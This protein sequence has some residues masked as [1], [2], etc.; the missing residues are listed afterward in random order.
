MSSLSLY[1][2]PEI[3][4]TKQREKNVQCAL[5]YTTLRSVTEATE[6]WYDPDPMSTIIEEDVD[7][8]KSYYEMPDE[9]IAPEKISPWLLRIELNR[10]MMVDKKLSMEDI[11]EKIKL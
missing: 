3:N 2:K 5:E 9:D 4:K 8:V 1:I 6:V 10:E 7:F 11:A